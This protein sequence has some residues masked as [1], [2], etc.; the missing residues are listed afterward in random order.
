MII[1]VD[2]NESK[3][4]LA[5]QLG[6]TDVINPQSFDKPIQEVVIVDLEKVV[7]LT[8]RVAVWKSTQS[9]D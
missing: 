4:E 2:I 1:G 7:E 5:Q 6:A 8:S 3:F 9:R